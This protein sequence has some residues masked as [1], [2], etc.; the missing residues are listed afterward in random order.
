M[1]VPKATAKREAMIRVAFILVMGVLGL[2]G[3]CEYGYMAGKICKGRIRRMS[4]QT[5][6]M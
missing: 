4:D 6:R 2:I 5:E 1:G 3:I